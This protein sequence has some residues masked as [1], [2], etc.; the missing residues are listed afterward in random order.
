MTSAYGGIR[1]G[2]GV[3]RH[4]Q[5]EHTQ[6][7]I[8]KTLWDE[9]GLDLYIENSP[10]FFADKVNTP[11]LIMNNDNDEAVPWYQGIEYFTALRRLGKQVWMLQYNG[12]SHNI[13][14][15]VNALDYTIRLSQFMDHFLKGAPMPVWMKYGLP[16]THKG[17]DMGLE[18]VEE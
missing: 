3:V 8:G 6:S 12:E 17:I 10:L 7:R 15:R 1:W 2:S 16:V 4:F 5:Y 11:L 14:K 9:G 13:S 18:L